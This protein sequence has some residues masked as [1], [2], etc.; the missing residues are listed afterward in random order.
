MFQSWYLATD[1]QLFILAPL[2]LY[3]LWKWRRMGV[4]ALSML[5]IASI[6][7]PLITTYINDADPTFLPYAEYVF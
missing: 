5:A 3:P 7:I 2:I 4:T 6:L 1:T